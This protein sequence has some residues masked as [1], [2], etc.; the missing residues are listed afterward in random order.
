MSQGTP[1]S[2]PR[3]DD[4][5]SHSLVNKSD[6]CISINNQEESKSQL[7]NM[8][9]NIPQGLYLSLSTA[10]AYSIMKNIP[11]EYRLIEKSNLKK[12]TTRKRARGNPSVRQFKKTHNTVKQRS[13]RQ[14]GSKKTLDF[15]NPDLI[16]IDNMID[17]PPNPDGSYSGS[18]P[19]PPRKRIRVDEAQNDPESSSSPHKHNLQALTPN[20]TFDEQN[21]L[22]INKEAKD[23]EM[24]GINDHHSQNNHVEPPHS[25]MKIKLDR[26]NEHENSPVKP[27][28]MTD[29]GD[30]RI[31]QS[32]NSGAQ[33]DSSILNPK[34]TAT[35]NTQ[36]KSNDSN[37]QNLRADEEVISDK[38]DNYSLEA[39][40]SAFKKKSERL[41]MAIS[42]TL[43]THTKTAPE[44]RVGMIKNFFSTLKENE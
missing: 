41:L 22:G 21:K 42:E 28:R 15:I 44:Y 43:H 17:H 26:I 4:Q 39:T 10:Q 8:E 37:C 5:D 29:N 35:F 31:S 38:D 3:K 9:L 23:Q 34:P 1:P 19:G 14:R 25:Q 11:P 12:T 7:N 18:Y 27:S 40:L 33:M 30:F 20:D 36:P 6:A 16:D 13:K 2:S 24:P 32:M